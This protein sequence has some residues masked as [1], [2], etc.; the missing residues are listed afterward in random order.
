MEI[1]AD[2]GTNTFKYNLKYRMQRISYKVFDTGKLMHC[3][4]LLPV[5]QWVKPSEFSDCL[6]SLELSQSDGQAMSALSSSMRTN[7]DL[8]SKVSNVVFQI[9][10]VTISEVE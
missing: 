10:G 3:F 9:L 6:G 2:E 7:I 8:H 5:R 1:I 4:D